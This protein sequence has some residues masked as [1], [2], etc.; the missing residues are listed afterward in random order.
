MLHPSSQLARASSSIGVRQRRPMIHTYTQLPPAVT[1]LVG[2]C[3]PQSREPHARAA[4]SP[5]PPKTPLASLSVEQLSGSVLLCAPHSA[6]G[7]SSTAA[8]PRQG[9]TLFLAV[10]TAMPPAHDTADRPNQ[11][12]DPRHPH[13][14]GQVGCQA[15]RRGARGAVSVGGALANAQGTGDG[16]APPP[17]RS[18]LCVL[19]RGV[20]ACCV[21]R[22][23]FSRDRCVA[24]AGELHNGRFF[25]C[26]T[27]GRPRSSSRRLRGGARRQKG[28]SFSAGRRRPRDGAA[29]C[30]SIDAPVLASRQSSHKR[31]NHIP[32]P[33]KGQV[34]NYPS[35]HLPVNFGTVISVQPTDKRSQPPPRCQ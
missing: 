27:A 22:V 6:S 3:Q 32:S 31:S 5:H 2:C 19:L 7:A 13:N 20:D 34:R 16:G 18:R 1:P 8:W 11:A 14:Q 25:S 17:A 26:A 24:A 4:G 15:G 21:G 29:G 10:S 12:A 28:V 35:S 23:H 30:G 9:A 33:K